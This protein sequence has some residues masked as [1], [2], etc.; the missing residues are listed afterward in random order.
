MNLQNRKRTAYTIM[1]LVAALAIL[2]IV[3]TVVA[4]IGY[5]SLVERLRSTTR[6]A[7]LEQAANVMESARA[8]PWDKLTADWAAAQ[9]LPKDD[10]FI[11]PEGRLTVKVE[12]EKTLPSAKRVTVEIRWVVQEGASERV[13]LVGLVSAR[14]VMITGGKP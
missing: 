4:Q 1:E 11:L 10:G 13:E 2:A 7:A 12:P 5:F 8:I 3:M 9:Q 6:Q 14:A